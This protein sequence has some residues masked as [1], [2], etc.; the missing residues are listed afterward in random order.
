MA[1]PARNLHSGFLRSAERFPTRPALEVEGRV[2]S[3]DE[4]RG[5]AARLAGLLSARAPQDG[6]PLTA[7]FAYRSQVAF[8]GVLAAL[9]RGHGY[10]PLNR[11][12]P[13]ART[14]LMLQR[15][16][17]SAVVV[18]AGSRPQLDEVL[19]SLERPLLV[20]L[21]DQD[22][23]E[24]E[25]ER[26]PKHDFASRRD[27]QETP[28]AEP[29]SV[30]AG[31]IAYLLFTSGSTGIPKGVMVK[32]SNVLHFIDVMTDRYEITEDDRF[33]QTFD[34]TFDLSVFDMFVAW[35]RGACLCCLPQAE[36]IK[37]GR[38]INDS[39]LT[40]WFSVPS[41]GLFMQR[42]GM[43]KPDR[44][45]TLRWSL[46]CGEPLPIDVARA[47]AEAAPQSI[48]ENL[49]GPTELTIAC[50]LYR[51]DPERTPAEAEFGLVPIGTPYPGLTTLVADE[52]FME[53]EPGADGELL[54]TGPQVTAGYWRDPEKTAVAFM[55]PP[56]RQETHYRTGD[57][58]RR[59]VGD[60]PLVYLGRVDNQVKI[61]GH[62]VELGEVEDSLRDASGLG[63]AIAVAWPRTAAGASGIVG[64]V[65]APSIDVAAT[66]AA[67]AKRLPDYM[68]PRQIVAMPTI[69]LNVNGKF[70][71][72]ELIRMLDEGLA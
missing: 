5:G 45:P 54:V 42:L 25:R 28:E 41:T 66:R 64:F 50:T 11:T 63:E 46:F 17:A 39:R 29:V 14:A 19:D 47:W 35:E 48:V 18:D 1:A 67:M 61:G 52:Q 60:A 37:P 69:P 59:P 56:G 72:N 71:R 22:D 13:P 34:M 15:S 44:Y 38:F 8:T 24:A 6:A 62:R 31:E 27:V 57:R 10:V 70:D 12:F 55:V 53:V 9:L 16:E 32:H 23:V 43:L 3:Y 49:Y 36:L 68:V 30:D 21:A 33:S 2:L 4:L 51:W 65:V 26:W 7:V 40:I 20:V 58:V